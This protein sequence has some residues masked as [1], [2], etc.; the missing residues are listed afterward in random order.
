MKKIGPK[1]GKP[2]KKVGDPC[3][4]KGPEV[5]GPRVQGAVES[6]R[7][8]RILMFALTVLCEAA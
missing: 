2:D 3:N 4:F 7:I 5:Q 1:V 6:Q 8:L